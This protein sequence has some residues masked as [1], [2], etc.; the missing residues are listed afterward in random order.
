[1][2]T[3]TLIENPTIAVTNR[4]RVELAKMYPTVSSTGD[5][6]GINVS[7]IH[8]IIFS[9]IKAKEELAKLPVIPAIKARPGRRNCKKGILEAERPSPSK[10]K[11]KIERNNRAVITGA[12]RF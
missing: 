6:G 4:P 10:A 9:N 2:G 1:M 11:L 3:N 12:N 8:R 7:G 5:S